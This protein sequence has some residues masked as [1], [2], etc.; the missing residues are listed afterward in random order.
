MSPLKI[1][2]EFRYGIFNNFSSLMACHACPS[3][4]KRA[5]STAK[6]ATTV[7]RFILCR[8]HHIDLA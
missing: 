2:I 1:K 7:P 6:L 4:S 5:G 3:M 8:S